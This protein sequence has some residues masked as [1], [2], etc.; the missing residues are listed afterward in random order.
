MN[1]KFFK[2]PV[3]ALLAAA[4]LLGGNTL[5]QTQTVQADD[6]PAKSKPKKTKAKAKSAGVAGSRNKVKFLSGS[7]ETPAQRSARLTR[8]C[9]G[10]VN[11]GAC[12]GYTN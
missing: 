1:N 6:K 3:V 4:V 12:A 11:A 5:A 8:E 10:A 9:K 2:G 7:E